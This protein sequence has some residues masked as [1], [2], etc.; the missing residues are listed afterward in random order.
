MSYE[1]LFAHLLAGVIAF[2]VV[3]PPVL[4]LYFIIRG[5]VNRFKKKSFWVSTSGTYLLLAVVSFILSIILSLLFVN[6]L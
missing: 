4:V 5:I 3:F 6:I 2:F 1:A